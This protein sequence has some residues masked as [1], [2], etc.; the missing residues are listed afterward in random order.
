MFKSKLTK[1]R[2]KHF[3]NKIEVTL[4]KSFDVEFLIDQYKLTREGFRTEYDRLKE[5]EDAANVRIAAEKE[6]EDPDKT[7]IEQLEKLKER[8]APDMAALKKQ[9]ET[10]DTQIE[11]PAPAGR[12]SLNETL[13]NLRTVVGLL[14]ER[15]AKL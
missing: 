10:I 15:V 13:D 2:K 4:K 14:R 8:Y 11:G 3:K 7:I 5:L 12:Q 9:M 1:L 6:K